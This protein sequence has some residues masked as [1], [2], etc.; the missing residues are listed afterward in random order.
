MVKCSNIFWP[1]SWIFLFLSYFSIF[2]IFLLI[3]FLFPFLSL[4]ISLYANTISKLVVQNEESPVWA[5][6]SLVSGTRWVMFYVFIRSKI[7]HLRCCSCMSSRN[8]NKL[9]KI[10]MKN[11]IHKTHI[12]WGLHISTT[13]QLREETLWDTLLLRIVPFLRKSI[14]SIWRKWSSLSCNSFLSFLSTSRKSTLPPGAV[15]EASLAS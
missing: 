2:C 10:I 5:H 14:L 3:F 9:V 1:Y 4:L 7:K 8:T 11:F 13:M 15:Q 6:E 12:C